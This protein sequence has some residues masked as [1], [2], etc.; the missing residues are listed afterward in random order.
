MV[1]KSYIIKKFSSEEI[2]WDQV[3][4]L[5]VHNLLWDQHGYA[6]VSMGQICYTDLGIHVKLTSYETEVTGRYENMNDPVYTD[7]CMEFFFQI[8]PE[9]DGRYLNFETNCLGTLLLGFGATRETRK[10]LNFDFRTVLGMKSTLTKDTI[11]SYS[12][13]FW[14]V[15]YTIPFSFLEELY[16]PIHVKSG[17]KIAANVYKCGD[18]TKYE[19]YMSWNYVGNEVPQFHSPEFFGEMIFE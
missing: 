8:N 1:K 19:H 14:S 10:Q 17:K 2:C 18:Q 13:P 12:G 16:G 6:P 5:N 15:E 4:A 3:P 11:G 9:T 7:S